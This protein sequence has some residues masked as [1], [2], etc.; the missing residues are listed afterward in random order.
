[1][2]SIGI[3]ARGLIFFFV[4]SAVLLR[5]VVHAGVAHTWNNDMFRTGEIWSPAILGIASWRPMSY[6]YRVSRGRFWIS[7]LIIKMFL[8]ENRNVFVM[9]RKMNH[10]DFV[11]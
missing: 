6:T 2:Y 4:G 9:K 8:I 5:R 3:F 7:K 10:A 11:F 1:M